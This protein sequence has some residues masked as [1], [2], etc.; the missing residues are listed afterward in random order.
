MDLYRK[1]DMVSEL[2]NYWCVPAAMQT[3]INIMEPG[4]P[5][6][7]RAT[8]LRL[9]RLARRLSTDK[10]DGK[11]AEP[12]GWARALTRLGYGKYAVSV[13]GWTDLPNSLPAVASKLL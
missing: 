3:M 4:R 6:K 13:R 10:L 8:Q 1:G 12:I 7:T 11:G 9:Y 2:T 5:D